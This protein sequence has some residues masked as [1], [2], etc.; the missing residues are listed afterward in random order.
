MALLSLNTLKLM[1]D[2][3]ANF[4]KNENMKEIVEAG[5]EGETND[6]KKNIEEG[7]R[8]K[9]AAERYIEKGD[10]SEAKG[11]EDEK[12]FKNSKET[13]RPCMEAISKAKIG[14][15]C[16]RNSEEGKEFFK[17]LEGG[18]EEFFLAQEDVDEMFDKCYEILDLI[19]RCQT[20]M[21]VAEYMVED[22]ETAATLRRLES[23]GSELEEFVEALASDTNCKKGETSKCASSTKVLAMPLLMKVGNKEK[24]FSNEGKREEFKKKAEK[25]KKKKLPK[26]EK[27]E[28]GVKGESSS[29]PSGTKSDDGSKS[30]PSGA[31]EDEGG[32][33]PSG[34]KSGSK[35]EGGSKPS[36]TK[37]SGTKGEGGMKPSDAAKR[38]RILIARYLEAV[39]LDT[40]N[41]VKIVASSTAQS[42]MKIGESSGFDT[43]TV[44][45]S[46]WRV[47]TSVMAGFIIFLL[48]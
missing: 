1:S 26:K 13:Q 45:E 11:K 8:R 21:S 34:E 47:V 38:A 10:F 22:E 16:L 43:T 23:E 6:S 20:I 46:V 15:L 18:K 25:I 17:M 41:D 29:K 27:G 12:K 9:K 35:E 5:K 33:K 30:K 32:S 36:G 24:S 44:Y 42:V 2:E 28:S 39:S 37:P 40:N 14:Y 3:M 19:A 4:T 48:K 31:K 7:D